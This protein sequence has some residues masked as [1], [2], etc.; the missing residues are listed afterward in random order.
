MI[1]L[2]ADKIHDGK[3]WLPEKTV[4]EVDENGRIIDIYLNGDFDHVIHYEGILCPG[5]VN[6]HCHVELNHMKAAVPEHT[7]LT[8]FLLQVMRKRNDYTEEQKL[9]A[10]ESA[11]QEMIENGI[12]AVGDIANTIDTLSLREKQNLHWHTFVESIG[13]V[14]ERATLSFEF[15]LK[16]WTAFAA[17]TSSQTSL[18]QSIV[19][20]A[21]YSV[22]DKLFELIAAHQSGATLSVHNQET[23]DENR[24]YRNKSGGFSAFFKEIGIDDKMFLPTGNTSLQSYSD[25]LSSDSPLMLVHNTFSNEEDIKFV[26][27]KFPQLFWCLCPNANLYIENRLPDIDLLDKSDATLCIGTD[28]L[29]SNHQLSV[30]A[31]LL[32]IDKNFAGIGWEKLLRWATYNGACALQLQEVTGSFEPDKT[33]GIVNIRPDFSLQRIY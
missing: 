29:A 25:W 9:L 19:P 5:F 14:P 20:H 13:F 1:L 12:V 30:M 11:L 3:K 10:R 17:Q 31:E 16:T 6:A 4:L 32:T 15:A 18:K 28:S 26:Q 23:E 8:G 24:Y 7:G 2:S 33:P 27:S 21:P 22:S